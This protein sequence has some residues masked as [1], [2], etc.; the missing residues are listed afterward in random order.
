MEFLND[1]RRSG[2]YYHGRSGLNGVFGHIVRLR[3]ISE[4]AV[5][6]TYDQAVAFQQL[7]NSPGIV[8][9]VRVFPDTDTLNMWTRDGQCHNFNWPDSKGNRRLALVGTEDER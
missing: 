8:V 1:K 7:K 4:C 9:K 6:A 5:M 2:S 3:P